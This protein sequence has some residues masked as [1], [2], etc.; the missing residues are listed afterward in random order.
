MRTRCAVMNNV[1]PPILSEAFLTREPFVHALAGQVTRC[2]CVRSV[3]QL[4]SVQGG[5]LMR[6]LRLIH[7]AHFMQPRRPANR[8]T[9]S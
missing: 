4:A 3:E 6:R 5:P 7:R 9:H 2:C 1:T 8:D